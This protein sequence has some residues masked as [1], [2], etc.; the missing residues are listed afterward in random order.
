MQFELL[1]FLSPCISNYYHFIV[2]I[3][4][5]GNARHHSLVRDIITWNRGSILMLSDTF[6][7]RLSVSLV[8]SRPM[9]LFVCVGRTWDECP[10]AA[11]LELESVGCRLIQYRRS[12]G[13]YSGTR[14]DGLSLFGPVQ[15]VQ[16]WPRTHQQK[17]VT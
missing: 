3:D 15:T 7:V 4:G 11:T 8:P 6:T 17:G 2:K 12:C 13:C 9:C 5:R 16:T 1:Q 14:V 10:V